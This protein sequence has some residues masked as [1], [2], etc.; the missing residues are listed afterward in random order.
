[1]P[2]I[3]NTMVARPLSNSLLSLDPPKRRELNA[4]AAGQ[5]AT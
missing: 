4:I 1:V 2:G 5:R 3:V